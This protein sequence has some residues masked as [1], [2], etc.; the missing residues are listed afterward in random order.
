MLDMGRRSGRNSCRT[1][2]FVFP[3]HRRSQG[4]LLEHGTTIQASRFCPVYMT[5]DSLSPSIQ[6][7]PSRILFLFAVLV[8]GTIL[9]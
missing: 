2:G 5:I 4:T 6:S 1:P 7:R 9:S 8:I 3:A